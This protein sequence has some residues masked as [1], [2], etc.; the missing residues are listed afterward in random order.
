MTC[1]HKRIF[2]SHGNRF[3][4]IGDTFFPLTLLHSKR[5]KLHT[6]LAFLGAIGL[7]ED[8]ILERLLYLGNKQEV[9]KIVSLNINLNIRYVAENMAFFQR[10]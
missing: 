10:I 9:T 3:A 4:A 7:R 2:C 8:P 6:I 1:F 5:P